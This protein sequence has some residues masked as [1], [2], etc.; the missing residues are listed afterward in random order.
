MIS[1]TFITPL[2]PSLRTKIKAFLRKCSVD[3]ILFTTGSYYC[4][5]RRGLNYLRISTEFCVL[6]RLWKVRKSC[7]KNA[8]QEKS[9]SIWPLP[10][11]FL[12]P[13]LRFQKTFHIPC[14]VNELKRTRNNNEVYCSWKFSN[15]GFW[16]ISTFRLSSFFTT[17]R[18]YGCARLLMLKLLSEKMKLKNFWERTPFITL[19]HPV[20]LCC[21]NMKL[22]LL[23]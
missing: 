10:L 2:F 19:L 3:L 5:R 4:K 6:F 22:L 8:R 18:I 13:P 21:W 17:F 11:S 16:R 12:F 1:I 15:S 7:K 23:S 20:I 14:M 9:F